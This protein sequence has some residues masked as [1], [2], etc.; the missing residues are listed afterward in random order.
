MKPQDLLRQARAE[1]CPVHT[2][3]LPEAL[4]AGLQPTDLLHLPLHQR[5]LTQFAVNE[6]GVRE[7]RLY[8]GDKEICFDEPE[9]F[10]FGQTLGR[11]SRFVAGDAL[12]WGSPIAWPR[13]RELLNQLV[14]Q[15]VLRLASDSDPA[16]RR[17]GEP[18]AQPSP[19]PPAQASVARSWHEC[20]GLMAE[21]T[22]R[23]L[24]IGYLE[25]VVPIFRVAHLALDAEGR[26]VGEANAFPAPLRL[27]IPTR[28]RTCIYS[29]TRYLSDK[30]M[31][32]TAL[33][34]MRAHWGP[35]MAA[36][37]QV[38]ACY[39]N[40]F[41]EAGRGWTV[42]HLERLST[43]VL[44]LPAYLLMRRERR[45]ESGA[46]HP[47]LSS[48]FRVTDGL[49]MVMHQMLFV[50]FGE[51]TL[52]ADA[53]MSS[54]EIHAYAERNFAFHSD[55]GVCAGP[56]AMIDEFLAVLVDGRLPRDGLPAALDA[57]LQDALA[58]LEPAMDY[59]LLGLQAYAAVF[60]LWPLMTR[61]YESLATLAGNW[62]ELEPA[63]AVQALRQWLDGHVEQLRTSTHLATEAWRAD[64]E[65]VYAD[66]YAHCSFGLAASAPAHALP[67]LLAPGAVP[68]RAVL[69]LQALMDRHC[70]PAASSA[71]REAGAAW[72]AALLRFFAQQQSVI[73]LACAVQRSIN[74][75][76]GRTAP[77]QPFSAA[78]IDLH[79]QLTGQQH[80]RLPYLID[81]LAE[82]LGLQAEISA[83]SLRILDTRAP[84]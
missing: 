61:A 36:L 62:A 32:V 77:A 55:H 47:V 52:A 53:P 19:L 67:E 66:M 82:H 57:G 24:D 21:L 71:S 37:L 69:A 48:M 42:G 75:L 58:D 27:D 46:L 14:E 3:G 4:P 20:P 64:R 39:L 56:A 28:W 41:P 51:P 35:M 80:R 65:S 54:A 16:E 68:A 25:L 34:S 1:A 17:P 8:C 73:R 12:H 78:D 22:G 79:I 9:L 6:D 5:T 45:V 13:L 40:R 31:N 44:A 7:L 10:A 50:P 43:A 23:P 33:K 2:A 70:G 59:A 74:R 30:P 26:Q 76:L 60:S 38:R 49:R 72:Q 15:G 84:A 63:P 11:Q 29:G 18:G 83:D 81:E